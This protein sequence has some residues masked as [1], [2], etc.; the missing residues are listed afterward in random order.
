[1]ARM[2]SPAGTMDVSLKRA[3][4]VKGELMTIGRIG[5][6]DSEIYF[7]RTEVAHLI[8]SSLSFSLLGFAITMPFVL[9]AEKLGWLKQK[10]A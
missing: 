7:S 1:M 4:V 10:K 2:I 5:V 3:D 6:W 9:L 8:N